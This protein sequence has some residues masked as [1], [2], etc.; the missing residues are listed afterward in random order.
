M[1]LEAVGLP[2]PLDRA[3]T[4][5]RLTPARLA[6]SNTGRR[7]S[8]QRMMRARWDVLVR[9]VP[10]GDDRGEAL[11]ISTIEDDARGLEVWAMRPDTHT[12]PPM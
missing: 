9:T 10:V 3:H 6:T 11:T 8:E 5:G 2:D 7:S 12:S 4:A 1:E